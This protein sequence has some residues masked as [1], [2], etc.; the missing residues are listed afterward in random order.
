M[1][2]IPANWATTN[3]NQS[4]IHNNLVMFDAN[5]MNLFLG[6]KKNDSKVL[7]SP[8]PSTSKQNDQK[9]VK[10]WVVFQTVHGLGD[11]FYL[12]VRFSLKI[13]KNRDFLS[14][15]YCFALETAIY[16]KH[17]DISAMYSTLI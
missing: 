2:Y 7:C 10:K 6:S 3:G 5:T 14:T 12:L 4:P 11:F 16:R 17:S 1:I 8:N 15:I 9:K 13:D